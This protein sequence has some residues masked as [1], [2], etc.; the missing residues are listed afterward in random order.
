MHYTAE[1]LFQIICELTKQQD[2]KY[3]L[4]NVS[5]LLHAV[6]TLQSCVLKSCVCQKVIFT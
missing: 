6:Y 5:K 1:Q 4:C 3:L 2:C